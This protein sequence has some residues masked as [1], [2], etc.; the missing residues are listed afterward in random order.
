[1]PEDDD[2]GLTVL[3]PQANTQVADVFGGDGMAKEA[4]LGSCAAASSA[5][6]LTRFIHEHAVWGMGGRTVARRDG[7]TSGAR[8]TAVSR[9]DDIDWVLIFNS[10]QS[11]TD[12][13]WNALVDA[14]N[15][16]LDDWPDPRLRASAIAR[17]GLTMATKAARRKKLPLHR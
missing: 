3:Q 4:A 7:S 14:I 11:F 6:A 2:L 15:T 10:R 1:M 12:V 5:T 16:A 9:A 17:V 13:Q 8:S